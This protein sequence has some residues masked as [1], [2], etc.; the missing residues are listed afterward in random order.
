[1]LING[2]TFAWMSEKGS[3][4]MCHASIDRMIEGLNPT[5]IILPVL[6][7]QETAQS[8]AIDYK[9]RT[10]GDEEVMRLI[11]YI[12]KKGLQVILKPMV[13]IENGT[14][15]AY[16]D[17]IDND[18]PCEPKWRDW[19]A[20]YTEYQTHYARMAE[21]MGVYMFIAGCELVLSERRDTEWR[22]VIEAVRGGY[23]GLVTYN[24]DKYQEDR[25]SWWDACDVISS[26]GYY[27]WDDWDGQLSRIEAVAQKYDK[28]FFFA[29]AG[30]PAVAGAANVPNDWTRDGA[31]DPAEQDKYYRHMF[32][33]CERYPF[34]RGFGLWDWPADLS[35]ADTDQYK[36]SYHI[37]GSKA[38]K[39]IRGYFD[40][41]AERS[42]EQK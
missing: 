40:R 19:F 25:V 31:Y 27:P 28:P 35:A 23:A 3:L 24:T 8:T 10:F 15:R 36:K 14:W 39:T 16:I 5:H 22:R 4:D 11:G 1:M 12:H 41:R 9:T 7:W 6:A 37:Y 13:N 29:E 26:S 42:N 33:A 21:D 18:V 32:E 34:V 30:C 17:F 38:E 2:V 20:S